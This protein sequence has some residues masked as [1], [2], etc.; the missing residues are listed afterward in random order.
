MDSLFFNI[1]DTNYKQSN[2]LVADDE[3]VRRVDI[4]NSIVF[5]H[6]NFK[7]RTKSIEL[8][9]MDRML[10]LMV[11][12]EGRATINDRI[13]KQSIKL[14]KGSITLF[15]SSRQDMLISVP[16][17]SKSKMVFIFIADF[18][19]KRYLTHQEGEPI[20]FIYKRLQKEISLELI[21]QEPLDAM[22][23]YI[24]YNLLNIPKKYS[25]QA[26]RAESR[27]LEF[28]IHSLSMLDLDIKEKGLDDEV[29][30]LAN[31]AK[32]ILVR[33]YINPPSIKKLAHMCATNDTK[34]K[35]VFKEVF[36][37]TIREY[38]QKLRLEEAN[39]LLKE[40]NLSVGEVAKRVGYRHQGYFSKLFFKKYGIYPTSLTKKSF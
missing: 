26:L 4:S 31:R 17:S 24:I 21:L 9:N 16:K 34:L 13:S 40:E 12:E 25:M 6:I 39:L 8:K 29:Y 3:I 30:L 36:K 2:I 1:L 15:V 19:L 11:I 28:I 18:F 27:I 33:D 23:R 22:S 10:M 37:L 35:R 20:D 14:S 38:I 7:D 32:K 5:F